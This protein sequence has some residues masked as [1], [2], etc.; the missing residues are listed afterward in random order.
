MKRAILPIALITLQL[1]CAASVDDTSHAN[2]DSA[3]QSAAPNMQIDWKAV[4]E[5]LGRTGAMQPGD[6]YRFG[7]P[8]GDLQVTA[9]GV[10]IRPALALGSWVA[11]KATPS[12]TIAMGDMVLLESEVAPV[13]SELQ[14]AA[15]A[16]TAVHHHVLNETPRI[17]YMHVHAHGDPVKIATGMREALALTGTPAPATAAPAAGE[18]GIDTAQIA[19]ALGYAGKVNGGVYQ[20]S[21]P[22]SEVIRD[23]GIEIPAS[24]GL[25]TAINFQ[26]TGGGKAAITGDFVMIASEVNTVRTIA[27]SEISRTS[28]IEVA[29]LSISRI[30]CCD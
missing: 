14:S 20:I 16:Q 13:M 24:M 8:R 2:A 12:G 17:V 9:A 5:A 26:P 7:M 19:S 11:F 1:A 15:I 3:S 28:R 10:R 6:V 21:V 29:K 27:G 25:G 30:S 23:G 4:E 18:L 22:R